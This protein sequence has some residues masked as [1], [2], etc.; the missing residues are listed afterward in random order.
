MQDDY[1]NDNYDY[2]W[3]SIAKLGQALFLITFGFGLIL[4]SNIVVFILAK[5]LPTSS[6][7]GVWFQSL[8][9]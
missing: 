8:L 3:L 9:A 4:V 5:A 7:V 1:F 6:S 2:Y